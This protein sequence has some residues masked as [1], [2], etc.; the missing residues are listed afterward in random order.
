MKIE[1]LLGFHSYQTP[2]VYATP[3]GYIVGIRV[4]RF[5]GFVHAH[6]VQGKY[7]GLIK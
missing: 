3:D 2:D 1:C 7:K 4:C 5:C 6:A